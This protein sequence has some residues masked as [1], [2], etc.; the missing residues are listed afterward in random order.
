MTQQPITQKQDKNAI[1]YVDYENTTERLRNYG[2]S[3]IEI[4]FF[5]VVLDKYME[6]FNIMECIAYAN[7][8]RSPICLSPIPFTELRNPDPAFLQ[9]REKLQ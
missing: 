4:N 2:V 5:P 1:I 9:Q 3:P 6:S 7:F 8:G